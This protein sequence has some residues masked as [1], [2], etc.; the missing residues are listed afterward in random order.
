MKGRGAGRGDGGRVTGGAGGVRKR[1]FFPFRAAAFIAVGPA[2]GH[3]VVCFRIF[4]FQ[5]ASQSVGVDG[6][7]FFVA[8]KHFIDRVFQ[9]V[10]QDDAVAAVAETAGKTAGDGHAGVGEGEGGSII[11]HAQVAMRW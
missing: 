1:V 6:P 11:G 7:W 2:F 8:V 4:Q 5:T 3:A 10:A 9:F